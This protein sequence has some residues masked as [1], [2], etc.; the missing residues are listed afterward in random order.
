MEG[1]ECCAREYAGDMGADSQADCISQLAL[2]PPH[3]P[4]SACV[5]QQKVIALFWDCEGTR[6]SVLSGRPTAGF[7]LVWNR[8]SAQVHDL[9]TE[10]RHRTDHRIRPVA[11][12]RSDPDLWGRL[13]AGFAVVRIRGTAKS[14]N[15]VIIAIGCVCVGKRCR[16][17]MLGRGPPWACAVRFV[18]VKC[19][20]CIVRAK[21]NVGAVR[22]KE[23]PD[24][25]RRDRVKSYICKKAYL[26]RL[27][28]ETGAAFRDE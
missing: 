27:C 3:F 14:Q 13:V 28:W 16:E 21:K 23:L 5:H 7:A 1:V 18:G 12:H 2:H 20:R 4:Q 11:R 25:K 6:W 24:W 9:G 8:G 15:F 19:C 26:W 17:T 22:L 10:N